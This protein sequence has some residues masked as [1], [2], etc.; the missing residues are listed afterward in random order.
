[1]KWFPIILFAW[2]LPGW[3]MAQTGG[4]APVPMNNLQ[5]AWERSGNAVQADHWREANDAA[6]GVPA[7]QWNWFRSEYDALNSR[8]NG[9]LRA[10][11]RARLDSIAGLLGATAPN[12]FEHH[13]ARFYLQFPA[14]AA[15]TELD[16]AFDLAPDRPELAAPMM[17]KAMRDG[18]PGALAKW[19]KALAEEGG[20][21]QPLLEVAQ[22]IL[23]C[24]PADAILFTNGDMDALP[25]IVAQLRQGNN[26]G[27]LVVDRRLLADPGY[28]SRIWA[29]AGGQGPPPAKGSVF[30]RALVDAGRPVYFALSLDRAW[31]DAFAEQLHAVG[32]AFRVGPSSPQD[33]PQLA[34]NWAAMRKPANAGPLSRNYLLPGTVLLGQLQRTVDMDGAARV[35]ADLRRLAAA[36]GAMDELQRRG[37]LKR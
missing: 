34:R 13:L 32:A 29:V 20:L 11:D 26:P 24:I 19:S 12:S 17:S 25:L 2:W 33:A 31:L 22:D 36:T 8:N 10:P 37:I 27:V 3:G 4:Q 14:Q 30:A 23:L 6:P 15:F 9:D 21:A 1:M 35:E 28:R 16:A 7:M 5:G 18:D